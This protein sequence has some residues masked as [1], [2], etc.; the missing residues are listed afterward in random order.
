MVVSRPS[1]FSGLDPDPGERAV[2]LAPSNWPNTDSAVNAAED[3]ALVSFVYFEETD[4][5]GAPGSGL[6]MAPNRTG[7]GEGERFVE[8][9]LAFAQGRFGGASTD[10][11]PET[12]RPSALTPAVAAFNERAT[13]VYEHVGFEEVDRYEQETNGDTYEFVAMEC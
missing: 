9:A 11:R 8:A 10:T 4:A 5:T 7:N 1:D 3:D 2:F 12:R 6:G 13:R